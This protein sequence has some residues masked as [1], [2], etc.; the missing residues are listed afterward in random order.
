MSDT[1]KLIKEAIIEVLELSPE[2]NLPITI[3]LQEELGLDSLNTLSLILT[4]EGKIPSL[5]ID[6]GELEPKHLNT[7]ESLDYFINTQL[8]RD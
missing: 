7:L 2:T 8:N 4:I 1:L 5:E 6:P 3:K